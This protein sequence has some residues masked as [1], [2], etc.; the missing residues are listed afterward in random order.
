MALLATTPLPTTLFD[1]RT[2]TW[3]RVEEAFSLEYGSRRGP[4]TPAG[5]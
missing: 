1:A 2:Q 5:D 3:R 4:F